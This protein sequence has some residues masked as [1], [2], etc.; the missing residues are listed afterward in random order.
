MLTEFSTLVD[1]LH[2]L[3]IQHVAQMQVDAGLYLVNDSHPRLPPGTM[4]TIPE[5]GPITVECDQTIPEWYQQA[6][7][8]HEKLTAA[9]P[10]AAHT[11]EDQPSPCAEESPEKES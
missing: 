5:S 3:Q 1:T 7:A 8:E 10:S 9:K 11:I 4:L 2:F 6:W